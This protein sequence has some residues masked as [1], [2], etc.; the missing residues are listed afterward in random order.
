MKAR[1]VVLV[2]VLALVGGTGV[3]AQQKAAKA[4]C[5]PE[6]VWDRVSTTYQGKTEPVSTYQQRKVVTKGHFVWLQHD[7]KRDTLPL[8]TP[9]DS[10][11]AYAL[12]GGAGTWTVVGD[13]YT[14]TIEFFNDP[15]LIGKSLTARCHI[16]GDR[17]YHAFDMADLNP[18]GTPHDTIVEIWRRVE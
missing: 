3:S 18:P 10:A 15:Q 11:R 2:A 13:R 16:E 4:S 7:L 17:W 6:G 5:Q 14:E 8:K 12:S 1:P 9:L